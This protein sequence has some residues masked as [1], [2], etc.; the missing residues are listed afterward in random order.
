MK[1]KSRKTNTQ[2]VMLFR[3]ER[4]EKSQERRFEI[5]K[6]SDKLNFSKL[7]TYLF[8][9]LLVLEVRSR[10]RGRSQATRCSLSHPQDV[11]EYF[12]ELRQSRDKR[13]EPFALNWRFH[14][15]PPAKQIK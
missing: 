8:S 2:C 14:F 11:R 4:P 6:T 15:V 7:N 9:G 13:N 3:M 5:Q 10:G 1:R 12:T